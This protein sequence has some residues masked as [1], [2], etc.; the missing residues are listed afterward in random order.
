MSKLASVS[1]I[2]LLSEQSFTPYMILFI[3]YYLRFTI[4]LCDFSSAF[5]G[6]VTFLFP[7]SERRIVITL[8]EILF[9]PLN[10]RFC[11]CRALIWPGDPN[12]LMTSMHN[13]VLLDV[14]GPCC[15]NILEGIDLYPP[16]ENT[17]FQLNQPPNVD[18]DN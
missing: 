2:C 10:C 1:Q 11:S 4:D 8:H 16:H 5:K 3:I 15:Y 18:A 14:L 17:V 6:D 12:F 13:F 7:L 9:G